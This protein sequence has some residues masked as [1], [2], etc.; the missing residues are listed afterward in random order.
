[1]TMFVAMLGALAWQPAHFERRPDCPYAAYQ[2]PDGQVFGF[3][4]V[5]L[6]ARVEFPLAYR[7]SPQ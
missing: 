1:M 3:D 2:S 5:Q 6:H 4:K 7:S